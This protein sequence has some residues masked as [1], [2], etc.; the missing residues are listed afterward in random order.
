MSDSDGDDD[1]VWC[2]TEDAF[3]DMPNLIL[4]G[5]GSIAEAIGAAMDESLEENGS[6]REALDTTARALVEQIRSGFCA[7]NRRL[8]TIERKY[9]DM[10]ATRERAEYD[11]EEPRLEGDGRRRRKKARPSR[12]ESSRVT[13]LLQRQMTGATS[14]DDPHR[15][16]LESVPDDAGL[17]FSLM[18]SSMWVSVLK[19]RTGPQHLLVCVPLVNLTRD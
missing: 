9:E 12:G 13:G 11:D 4:G 6:L 8:E 17:S 10:M 14:A 5:H 19:K 3:N 16:A 7:I 15:Q 18:R 1:D 2:L